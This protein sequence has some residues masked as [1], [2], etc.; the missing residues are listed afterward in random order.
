MHYFILSLLAAFSCAIC[1]GTAAVLQKISADKEKTV[2]SLDARLLLRLFQDKPYIGGIVL[3][4]LGWALTIYAV[5]YLP[6]FL[7]EAIIATNIVITALIERIFRHRIL[8]KKS[9]LAIVL[10]IFGL[11]ILAFVSS[12]EKVGPI[13]NLLKW[14]ILMV[15]IPLAVAGYILARSRSQRATIGL[16]I[17]AGLA[18]GGTSIVGRIFSFSRPIWHTMY[19]PLIFALVASGILGLLLFSIALQ[20]MHA[21]VINATVATSQSLI[22][23]IVGIV[24]LG[25]HA[26]NGMWYLI[27]LGISLALFGVAFLTLS[28]GNRQRAVI[29]DSP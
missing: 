26:R 13:S 10:I 9:Y 8:P 28:Y 3:D 18:F 14:F 27:V 22:P 16:A 19:S 12:P 17:L 15:P 24:V 6:L 21:T 2:N 29:V 4:L 11:V 25:D 20:R 1:N 7:V 23:S 5:Q